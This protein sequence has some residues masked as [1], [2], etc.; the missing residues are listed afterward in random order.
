MGKLYEVTEL[1]LLE[2]IQHGRP[3]ALLYMWSADGSKSN[4][5]WGPPTIRRNISREPQE[6]WTQDFQSGPA[7][8]ND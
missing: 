7:E 2:T 5:V 3:L 4:L 8:N 1:P 6:T